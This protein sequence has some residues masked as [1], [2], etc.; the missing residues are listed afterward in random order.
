ME[1]SL[2]QGDATATV[3]ITGDVSIDHASDLRQLLLQAVASDQPL[4]IN[5]E[6]TTSVDVTAL[7]ILCSVQHGLSANGRALAFHPAVSAPIAAAFAGA[8]LDSFL[9][10]TK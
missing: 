1:I 4:L 8:G 9:A 5:L 10:A 3:R 6:Q 7:Q 2:E